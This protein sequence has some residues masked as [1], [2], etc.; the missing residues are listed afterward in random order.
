VRR[1]FFRP[2]PAAPSPDI[3]PILM[4]HEGPAEKAERPENRKT[5]MKWVSDEFSGPGQ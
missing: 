1:H 2:A 4:G 3:N 5:P